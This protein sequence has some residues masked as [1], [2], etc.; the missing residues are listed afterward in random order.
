M[1]K[2]WQARSSVIA[3]SLLITACVIF[4]ISHSSPPLQPPV[5]GA[6]DGVTLYHDPNGHAVTHLTELKQL[7]GESNSSRADFMAAQPTA[8]WLSGSAKEFYDSAHRIVVSASNTSSVPVLVAYDLPG[9]DCAGQYSSGGATSAEDYLSHIGAM[10]SGIGDL[11]AIVILEPDAVAASIHDSP[12]GR[13]MN[14]DIRHSRQ[15]LL[16]QA[17]DILKK[18]PHVTVYLDAGNANWIQDLDALSGALIESGIA[19]ADGFSLNVSNFVSNADSIRFGHDLGQRLP[20]DHFVIDSSRNGSDARLAT[21]PG[22]SW[23]NPPDRKLGIAPTT[24]TN[25]GNLDAYLWVK[26]PGDSDG[27]CGNGAPTAGT[28]W[29]EYAAGLITAG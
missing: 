26:Q 2:S 17:I 28:W 10:G 29:P 20:K 11:P 21:G 23:C 15:L 19:R 27:A 9:R 5:V 25:E 18:Q 6:L 7:V 22:P 24:Q 1:L 13:C 4:V 3:L 16:G 8:L 12:D 14:N